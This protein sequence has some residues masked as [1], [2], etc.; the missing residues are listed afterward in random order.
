MK[1]RNIAQTGDIWQFKGKHRI[2]CCDCTDKEAV[3]KLLGNS[4]FKLLFTSPPYNNQRIYKDQNADIDFTKLMCDFSDAVI[5]YSDQSHWIIN[6]GTIRKNKAYQFYYKEWLEYMES[7]KHPCF[8]ILIW[9]KCISRPG[10]W[11]NALPLGHELLFQ[12]IFND[13]ELNYTEPVKYRNTKQW[14]L[15]RNKDSSFHKKKKICELRDKQKARSIISVTNTGTYFQKDYMQHTKEHGAR[16]LPTLPEKIASIWTNEKDLVFDPFMGVA[17][18]MI[19][20]DR[21][22]RIAYGMEISPYYIDLVLTQWYKY[23]E[24]DA[25]NLVTGKTF[26]DTMKEVPEIAQAL[27]NKFDMEEKT[28][29]TELETEEA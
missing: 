20:C 12:F 8:E 28:P 26:S 5:P 15:T 16:F 19:G 6:L 13:I 9:D 18:T 4:R 10:K 2:M 25:V 11:A 24:T 14:Y 1:R 27:I 17:N 3:A 7:I 29:I 21:I 22:D 23:F